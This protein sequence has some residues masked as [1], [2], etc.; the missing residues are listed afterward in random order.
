MCVCVFKHYTWEK[1]LRQGVCLLVCVC[2]MRT[3]LY[4][5]FLC[6]CNCQR[7]IHSSLIKAKFRPEQLS[8]QTPSP[9]PLPED[10]TEEETPQSHVFFYSPCG[11]YYMVISSA[12]VRTINVVG[13]LKALADL[14]SLTGRI[15]QR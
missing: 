7:Y 14:I 5:N 15:H 4:K 11:C 13:P 9:G 6:V 10:T 2:F 12:A 3:R 1:A 8:Q